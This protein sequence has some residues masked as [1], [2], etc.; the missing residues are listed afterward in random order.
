MNKKEMIYELESIIALWEKDY[1]LAGTE[2]R[3]NAIKK[4]MEMI[5]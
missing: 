4:I 1:K 2:N 3:V 5:K